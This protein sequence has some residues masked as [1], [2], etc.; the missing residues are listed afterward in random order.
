[1]NVRVSEGTRKA[2]GVPAEWQWIVTNNI[3][4]ECLGAVQREE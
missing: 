2:A 1:M 4:L 3:A